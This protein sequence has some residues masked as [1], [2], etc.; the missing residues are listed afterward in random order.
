MII[1]R[2]KNKKTYS[3]INSDFIKTNKHWLSNK[4]VGMRKNDQN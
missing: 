3:S 1:F 4:S 2:T